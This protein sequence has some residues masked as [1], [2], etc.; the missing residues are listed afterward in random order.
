VEVLVLFAGHEKIEVYCR[1]LLPGNPQSESLLGVEWEVIGW[2][3]DIK[4]RVKTFSE[5]KDK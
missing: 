5:K 4:A 3:R 1:A 2:S